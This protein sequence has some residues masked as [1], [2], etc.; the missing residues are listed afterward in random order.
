MSF[1]KREEF[2]W[3]NQPHEFRPSFTAAGTQVVNHEAYISQKVTA[4]VRVLHKARTGLDNARRNW[5]RT[6]RNSCFQILHMLVHMP[7]AS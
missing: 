6:T 7:Q 1:I 5:D 3:S 4:A 2:E